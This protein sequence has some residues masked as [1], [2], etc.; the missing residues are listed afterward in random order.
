MKRT[1]LAASFVLLAIASRATF[2]EDPQAPKLVF[3]EKEFIFPTA[4]VGDKVTHS[5]AFK[6]EGNADLIIRKV[7]TSCGCTVSKITVDHVKPGGAG[8]IELTLDTSDKL[9]KAIYVRGT[10]YSN[11]ATQKATGPNTTFIE[12]KGE[13]TT[14]FKLMPLGAY[15]AQLVRGRAPRTIDVR[16]TG[17]HDAKDGWKVES[18][19]VPVDWIKVDPQTVAPGVIA[20]KVTVLPH[21]PAG[22]FMQYVTV[23][24]DVKVQPTFRFP[25]VGQASGPVRVLNEIVFQN[26]HRGIEAQRVCLL[27]RIDGT[28][29]GVR[30]T[31]ID[32]DKA[33][34]DVSSEVAVEGVRSDVRVKV[35]KDA[36]PGPFASQILVHLDDPEQPIIRIAVLMDLLPRVAP[37]PPLLLAREGASELHVSVPIDG[38][39]LTGASVEPADAF[40]LTVEPRDGTRAARVLLKPVKPLKAGDK[41]TVVLAT[42]VPGEE[43]VRVP[44]EVVPTP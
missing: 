43:S 21:V 23:R 3:A 30:I 11:D 16:V 7:D 10:V 34:L 33:H 14:C 5:F 28:A 36:P 44:V 35:R 37:D 15:F 38:G 25:V 27:E 41:A 4:T 18:I 19:D 42:D 9:G 1:A 12:L 2:G 20:F 39:A 24:T 17:D 6:N 40:A 29:N 31:G 22:D 8:S 13:V 26:L 32:Y